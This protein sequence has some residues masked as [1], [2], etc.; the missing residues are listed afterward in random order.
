MMKWRTRK[1]VAVPAGILLLFNWSSAEESHPPSSSQSTHVLRSSVM[2]G[3]G[4][5][6]QTGTFRQLGTMAQPTPAGVCAGPGYTL[7]A[8]FAIVLGT[9]VTGIEDGR[10]QAFTDELLQNYPNPFSPTTRIEYTV[11]SA[12]LVQITIYDVSGQIVRR[13]VDES[14]PIGRHRASW[15]GMTD[16]GAHVAL[17]IYF[18]RLRIGA[19]TEVKKMVLVK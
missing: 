6:M 11:A 9:T 5:L 1:F 10:P 7:R 4:G 17:G 19:F 8:G 16:Q 2:C 13:L 3:G 12:G 14:K 18:C 15:N